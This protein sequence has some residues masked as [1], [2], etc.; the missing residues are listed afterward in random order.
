MAAANIAK[1]EDAIPCF[2]LAGVR[3]RW[4][5][6]PCVDPTPKIQ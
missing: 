6:A 1:A 4:A 3:M 2:R 5:A